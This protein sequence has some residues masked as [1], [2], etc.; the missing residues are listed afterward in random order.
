M[1]EEKK[2]YIIGAGL[3]GLSCA[4]ALEQYGASPVLLESSESLGGRVATEY[5]DNFIF[6]RG[7]QV[8]LE[9]YPDVLSVLS[10]ND[11]NFC[12]FSSGAYII[13]NGLFYPFFDPLRHPASLGTTLASPLITLQDSLKMALLRLDLFVKS[14]RKKLMEK[15]SLASTNEFLE[16][17][18]FSKKSLYNFFIPFFSGIFLEERLE[19]SAIKFLFLFDLFSRGRAGIPAK[20]M[21][22]IPQLIRSNLKR[23]KI[24]YNTQVVSLDATHKNI[25]LNTDTEAF[26]SDIVIKSC[27][28]QI[29]IL[30]EG[31]L[32]DNKQKY[33]LNKKRSFNSVTNIYCT[34][35]NASTVRL[36]K[37]FLLPVLILNADKKDAAD[38]VSVVN[39][40]RVAPLYSKTAVPL[41]SVVVLGTHNEQ[42][43]KENVV[44]RLSK[45]M[46]IPESALNILKVYTIPEALPFDATGYE[47]Q[48][49]SQ[50]VIPE[51]LYQCGDFI[52]EGSINGAVS[53]GLRVAENILQCLQTK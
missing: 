30:Q 42:K 5:T 16:Q 47:Q 18:G 3:A 22:L 25:V 43:V 12:Y 37:P 20:G 11:L 1:L 36:P 2:I 35:N 49:I 50:V 51:R 33:Q 44:M 31:V 34:V 8:Y 17:Y 21:N 14:R 52:F 45:W 10:V 19:T 6:D 7:F 13:K 23:S 46:N 38:I 40:Q 4:Y 32:I 39:L 48:D 24:L 26:A 15:A 29:K 41:F 9:K 53:S 27:H 28:N